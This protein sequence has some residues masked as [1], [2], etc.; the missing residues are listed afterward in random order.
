MY[1]MRPSVRHPG[2]ADLLPDYR[3]LYL[4]GGELSLAAAASSAAGTPVSQSGSLEEE[5]IRLKEQKQCKVCMDEDVGVVFLPCGHLITCVNCAP[6]LRDC[7]LCRQP[8]RGTVR[9]YLS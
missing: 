4:A 6:A 3:V 9:T 7:P 2:A 5:Y 8:I 1:V